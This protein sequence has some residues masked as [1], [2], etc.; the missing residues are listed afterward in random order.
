MTNPNIPRLDSNFTDPNVNPSTL[1]GGDANKGIYWTANHDARIGENIPLP[2]DY[3]FWLVVI[4]NMR[5]KDGREFLRDIFKKYMDVLQAS[6][7]HLAQASMGGIL[8]AYGSQIQIANILEHNYMAAAGSAGGFATG[9]GI[10]AGAVNAS[11]I[12]SSILGKSYDVNSTLI[13]A[14]VGVPEPSSIDPLSRSSAMA[15]LL[16]A[17][18]GRGESGEKKPNVD[19]KP[20]A[21]KVE[22]GT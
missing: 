21:K 9:F 2:V 20:H 1:S 10:E 11:G 7:G 18:R 19:A 22:V 12:L 13:L 15:E 3:A 4:Y 14:G 16:R 8:A 6:I 17:E 5:S